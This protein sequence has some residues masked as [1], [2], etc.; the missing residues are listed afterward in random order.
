ME[1]T[2][3]GEPDVEALNVARKATFRS[4][5]ELS[6]KY[7]DMFHTTPSIAL[8]I[9]RSEVYGIINQREV[10]RLIEDDVSNGLVSKVE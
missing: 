7:G 9:P 2:T 8:G 3:R 1:K 6:L 10:A 5:L 4:T